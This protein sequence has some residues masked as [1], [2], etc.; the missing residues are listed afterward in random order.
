MEETLAFW[1]AVPAETAVRSYEAKGLF[2]GGDE[3]E[4]RLRNLPVERLKEN[5]QRLCQGFAAVLADIRAVGSFRLKEVTLNVEVTAEGGFQLIG[6]ATV[7]GKGA[8]TLT[9][10]EPRP[11]EK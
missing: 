4:V 8:I 7:G 11:G 10:A 9:F 2:R 1:V 6:T 5:L 3:A